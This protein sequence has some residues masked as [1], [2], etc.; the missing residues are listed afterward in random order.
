[1][2]TMCIEVD[3]R[4]GGKECQIAF[5]WEGDE[6]EVRKTMA[7]VERLA[8]EAKITPEALIQSVLHH[9]PSMET[10]D[11]QARQVTMMILLYTVL[12]LPTQ[13]PD[14]PGA[15]YNYASRE[16]ITAAVKVRDDGVH[17]EIKG[18]RFDA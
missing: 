3:A 16:Q 15:L 6:E 14:R 4:V 18:R 13:S 11:E 10:P 2:G 12:S 9:L 5:N 7:A 8:D 17:F 1:M